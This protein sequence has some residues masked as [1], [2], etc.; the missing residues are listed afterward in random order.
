MKFQE[1]MAWRHSLSCILLKVAAFRYVAFSFLFM[2]II[3]A[4]AYV[5]NPRD[6]KEASVNYYADHDRS[7]W[8]TIFS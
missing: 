1:N 7:R 4:C 8:P 6:G 2:F 3:S 5:L